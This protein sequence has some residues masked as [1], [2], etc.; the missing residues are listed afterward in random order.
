[1]MKRFRDVSEA[2][3]EEHNKGNKKKTDKFEDLLAQR[4][5]LLMQILDAI[6]PF[7][8]KTKT[9]EAYLKK[10]GGKIFKKTFCP[11]FMRLR[12]VFLFQNS[13]LLPPRMK[14][15]PRLVGRRQTTKISRTVAP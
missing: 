10:H 9:R 12:I 14:V 15:D 4:N 8:L 2:L 7:H 6:V 11:H 1:M 5:D 3:R 13:T